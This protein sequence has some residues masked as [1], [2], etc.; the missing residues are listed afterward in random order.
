M[1][2]KI[3]VSLF[4]FMLCAA[5]FAKD[6]VASDFIIVKKKGAITLS[7]RWIT[8]TRNEP[9]RELKAE[10]LVKSNIEEVI[11]LLKNQSAG[12]KWNKNASIYKI[13]NSANNNE[14]INYIKYDM[15]PMFSDQECCLLY[16]API[17]FPPYQ[18]VFVINFESATCSSFPVKPA[19]KRITGVMGQWKIE[20][21]ENNFLKITYIISSDRSSTIPRFI[22]DP[23]VH[24]SLFTTMESFK[25]LLE[26]KA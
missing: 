24:N 22:S 13:A 25:N 7:E 15:P 3:S 6:L 5:C 2:K 10:F 8:G 14:W 23:I 20:K 16:K 17:T 4:A 21:Q 18:N 11:S 1:M 12:I 9:V 19:V 26:D